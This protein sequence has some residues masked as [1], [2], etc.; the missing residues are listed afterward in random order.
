MRTVT[1]EKERLIETLKNNRE[2]HVDTFE[3]TLEG[4]RSKAVELLKEHID[5]IRDGEVEQV[6][7]YLPVPENYEEA[8][9]RAIEM[10]EWEE[11]SW[12][13]L[14]ESEFDQFVRD[15]WTWKP[16]FLETSATYLEGR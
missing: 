1:V 13:E 3:Q 10:M 6:R 16:D 14:T 12:V 7:V 11:N 8:Y 5:R 4:Y 2:N 15:N 9:D